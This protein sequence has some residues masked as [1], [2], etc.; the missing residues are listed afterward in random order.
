MVEKRKSPTRQEQRNAEAARV[1]LEEHRAKKRR[2]ANAR[3]SAERRGMMRYI[4]TAGS[5]GGRGANV[6]GQIAEAMYQR[7]VAKVMRQ[8]TYTPTDFKQLGKIVRA[9]L[10][11]KWGDVERLIKEWQDGLKRRACRVKKKDMQNIASG[12]NISVEA[13]NTRKT[14]C[15]KIKNKL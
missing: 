12:L 11:R 6:R 10:D 14:I 15:A 4:N 5:M 3:A 13:K 1:A 2:L 9:R 7:M 8:A